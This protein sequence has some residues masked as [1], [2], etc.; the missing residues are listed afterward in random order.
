[1]PDRFHWWASLMCQQFTQ[2]EF[3]DGTAWHY[4][5]SIMQQVDG[6]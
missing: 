5:Q 4:M 1:M 3:R 2:A 6:A